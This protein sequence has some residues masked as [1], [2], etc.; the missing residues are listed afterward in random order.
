MSHVGGVFKV[1]G[2]SSGFLRI[3]Q[4]EVTTFYLI[5]FPPFKSGNL[6]KF[7]LKDKINILS[8]HEQIEIIMQNCPVQCSSTSA[9]STSMTIRE[10]LAVSIFTTITPPYR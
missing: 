2:D 9:G 4:C 8:N 7:L 5:Y 6:Q 3:L 10:K 1:T